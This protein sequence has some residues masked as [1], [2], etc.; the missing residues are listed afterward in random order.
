ML[1]TRN[2]IAIRPMRHVQPM[3]AVRAICAGQNYDCMT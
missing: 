2:I 3:W 1:N